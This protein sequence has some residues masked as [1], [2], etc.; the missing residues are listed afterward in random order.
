M[1]PRGGEQPRI[2]GRIGT[3]IDELPFKASETA[4]NDINRIRDAMERAPGKWVPMEF[5][6]AQVAT[7]RQA[8][9]RGARWFQALG[10]EIA[11]RGN[12]VYVRIPLEGR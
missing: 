12:V 9:I 8:G 11:T 2:E 5:S 6:S 10:A 1:T 3:P 4:R 7:K